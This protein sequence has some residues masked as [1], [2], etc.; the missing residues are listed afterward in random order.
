V[1]PLEG[2]SVPEI[3][4]GKTALSATLAENGISVGTRILCLVGT[5]PEVIKMVP[6]MAALANEHWAELRIL[7]TA[8]HRGLLDEA[9]GHFDIRP[10]RDL[11]IMRD[12]Q[13]LVGLTSRL[14]L[15]LDEALESERPGAVLVQGD[16]T[17]V[18]SASLACF[19]RGI[20][21]GHVEAGLRTGDLRNPFPE[22]ANRIVVTRFARWHFAPTQSARSNLLREGIRE[23]D[24]FVT[25]NTVI[26]ALLR[27]ARSDGG[28]EIEADA[29][30]RTILVTCHRRESFGEPFRDICR[31][32]SMIASRNPDVRILYPVHP[33][34]HVR[35][36]AHELLGGIPN[37]VLCP[38]LDY[39][40]FVSAMKASYAIITDSGGVQEEAPA[41]GRPVL[42]VR[43]KTERPEAVDA[44]VVKLVGTECER[45]VE[46]TQRL[47]D[48]RGVY[49]EMARGVSP[50]GDGR[51]AER[52][53]RVLRNHFRAVAPS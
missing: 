34:P 17:T 21:V 18:M 29:H 3:A 40:S 13:T 24:I 46:E 28:P 39:P 20:P 48:D 35:N 10:D 45:I 6:V 7:A 16:T 2:A 14:L 8:Q 32:L 42:V 50:Y 4:A 1:G 19:Y 37:V 11:D 27:T 38:P 47:L 52:I 12:G 43:D 26:D 22:E 36:R 31:A 25:G 33:N 53:V 23:E 41:L 51:A 15:G 9:L 49:R 44:N 30:A 5:R